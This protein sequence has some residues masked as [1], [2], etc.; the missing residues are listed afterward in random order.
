MP[1]NSPKYSLANVNFGEADAQHDLFHI[2]NSFYKNEAWDQVLN[3][4]S[5]PF[6]VGRKGAGK[7]ALA[8]KI[9]EN[10][11]EDSNY[12]IINIVPEE[13]RHVE[14][15]GLLHELVSTDTSWQYIYSRIWEG[16]LLGQIVNHFLNSRRLYEYRDFSNEFWKEIDKIKVICGF[17]CTDLNEAL[18]DKIFSLVTENKK[19]DSSAALTLLR[20]ELEPYKWKDFLL[21]VNSELSRLN[22]RRFLI[23]IDGLDEYWDTSAPSLH[24]LAQLV[25][26]TKKLSI[27]LAGNAYFYVCIRDNIFRSLVDTKAIEYDKYES[28]VLRLNWNSQS[29]FE[30][31]AKRISPDKEL[32]TH[33]ELEVLHSLLPA[34]IDDVSIENYIGRYIL[35]RPRDYINFFT[36]LQGEVQGKP[37][38]SILNILDVIRKYK[39]NRL[40]EL[41][42]EFGLT[43][44]GINKLID[45]IQSL[46]LLFTKEELIHEIRLLLD[47]ETFQREAPL[48]VKFYGEPKRIASILISLG[49]IGVLDEKNKTL[50]FINEF[51]ETRVLNILDKGSQFG[52]HPVYSQSDYYHSNDDNY[53]LATNIYVDTQSSDYTPLEDDEATLTPIDEKIQISR[54]KLLSNYTSIQPGQHH[55]AKF[56]NWTKEVFSTVF[57]HHVFNPRPQIKSGD[58]SKRFELVFDMRGSVLA[59][60]NLIQLAKAE[61]ILVECKNTMKPTDADVNKTH[62]DLMS[63]NINCALLVYRSEKIEPEGAIVRTLR[64]FYQNTKKEYVI[65]GITDKLLCNLLRKKSE[66]KAASTFAKYLNTQ[67]ESHFTL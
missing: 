8:K 56:E 18:C 53:K 7:T 10:F 21:L 16:I 44:P 39:N 37:T 65:F 38:A 22:N 54:N 63:L 40:V 60:D 13:F 52:I 30:L 3:H 20:K 28:S 45:G 58:S 31:I 50:K 33:E 26:E 9:E 23:I 17:Y 35:A 6:I 64:D 2:R 5:V 36:I 1:K 32:S 41:D 15:R 14:I 62:R 47:S 29:L 51:S 57:P 49:I 43:Y 27:A 25:K 42:N 66:N 11:R 59:F 46:E 67:V 34:S 61:K 24:F 48:L 4:R 55:F 19:S 12:I